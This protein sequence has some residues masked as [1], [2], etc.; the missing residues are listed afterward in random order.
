MRLRARVAR[1]A[2]AIGE[3]F[4]FATIALGLSPARGRRV[5]WAI[6]ACEGIRD[7]VLVLVANDF[8]ALV[9]YIL[10][11]I[12]A[13]AARHVAPRRVRVLRAINTYVFN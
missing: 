12:I 10:V 13:I 5:F 8:L 1:Y 3:C 2:L 9:L 7:P 11:P 6:Q 4:A